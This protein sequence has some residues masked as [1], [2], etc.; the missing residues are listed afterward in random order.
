MTTNKEIFG[1]PLFDPISS[2]WTVP[3]LESRLYTNDTG[4]NTEAANLTRA[5]FQLLNL[6]MI[7]SLEL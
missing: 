4:S 3:Y 6:I 1:I 7:K 2:K 5:W